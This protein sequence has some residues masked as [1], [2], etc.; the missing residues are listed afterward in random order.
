MGFVGGSLFSEAGLGL[1]CVLNGVLG[2][3]LS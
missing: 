3:P 2:L 1:L